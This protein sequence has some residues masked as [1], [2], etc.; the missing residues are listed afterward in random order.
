MSIRKRKWT[1]AKGEAKTAWVVDYKDQ[2]GVRALRTFNKQSEAKEFETTMRGEVRDKKHV[3][4][5]KSLTVAEAGKEWLKAVAH[6]RGERGPAEASTLR[7]YK[8]H[9]DDYI[10]PMLG[11]EKLSDLSKADVTKFRAD[12]LA[13]L[14]RAMA[15]KVL[16]S[17][18]GIL[19]EMQHQDQVA[20]NVAAT[21]Q[22]GTG[23]RHKEDVVVPSI[24]DIKAILAKLDELAAQANK[25]WAAAWVKRRAFLATAVHT[26]MR[27][28]ELRG[29]PWASVDLKGATIE[30]RQ[31]AD[32]KGKI[33]PPKSKAGR[34]TINIPAAL[35][36]ILR[37]WKL[38]AGGH[39]LVFATEE[40]N[41]ESLANIFNRAWKPIQIEAHICEP[42]RDGAGDIVKDEEGAPVMEP[43]YN[44]HALRH[45][46]A[47]MLIADNANPKE[48]Q[49]ELGHSSIQV[50]YDLYGHLFSDEDAGRRRQE[51]SERLAGL[52]G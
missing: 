5:S 33:G 16:Q 52:L 45:F 13:K 32:E 38:R 8:Q 49:A 50:T 3:V 21:V 34:R 1:T 44:F 51:R 46:H 24:S 15:K 36:A 10:E 35:V 47:S 2:N 40:G 18:K 25:R 29:L 43:R 11:A 31:R 39:D 22:I 19:S 26:G 30:V 14:S 9:V 17:L 42:K 6:G 27:A 37:E 28:S 48:V 41:A 12:L 20:V 7:Q 4:R 23:G